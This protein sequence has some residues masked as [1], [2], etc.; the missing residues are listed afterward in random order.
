MEKHNCNEEQ[1]SCTVPF[2]L[3][4]DCCENEQC[5]CEDCEICENETLDKEE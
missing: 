1:C 2:F 5:D 3:S 4:C